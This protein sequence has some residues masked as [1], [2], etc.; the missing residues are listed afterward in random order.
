MSEALDK[1]GQVVA[2]SFR[3]P[4]EGDLDPRPIMARLIAEKPRFADLRVG[5]AVIM[6]VIRRD[7]L[8]RQ[9]RRIAGTMMLVRG[10]F[11]GSSRNFGTWLLA[12]LCG[13]MLP[14]YV[15]TLDDEFWREATPIVREA[16]VFHELCHCMH[17]TDRNGELRFTEEGLP[18]WGIQ[19]HDIEEF[20]DVVKEYGAWEP[21]IKSFIH[22]LREGGAIP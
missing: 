9:H 5:E 14:D 11:Q 13:G 15:M 1:N 12:M 3:L 17:E 21:G 7:E 18:Q 22:A 10:M 20:D 16:L 19:G 8:I 2:E 4:E 6:V